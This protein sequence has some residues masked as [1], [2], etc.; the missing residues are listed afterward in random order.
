[1]GF[2]PVLCGYFS[3]QL[4]TDIRLYKEVYNQ[5]L[6]LSDRGFE[7]CIVFKAINFPFEAIQ[8]S[9]LILSLI[10][11]KLRNTVDSV[12]YLI[13]PIVFIG[14]FNSIRQSFAVTFL[15]LAVEIYQFAKKRLGLYF[16]TYFSISVLFL[17]LAISFHKGVVFIL[18]FILG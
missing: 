1:M 7:F 17:L 16:I 2:F 15:F 5:Y 10:I 4:E 3:L 12:I 18:L 14:V 8:V 11:I 6:Y 13:G 9:L